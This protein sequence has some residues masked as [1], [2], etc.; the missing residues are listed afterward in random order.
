MSGAGTAAEAPP[1]HLAYDPQRVGDMSTLLLMAQ[2]A[3]ASE[4]ADPKFWRAC[5]R[6][7]QRFIGNEGL[8]NVARFVEAAAPQIC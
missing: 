6:Q 4:Y 5:S 7:A 2:S 8:D 1:A 3:N